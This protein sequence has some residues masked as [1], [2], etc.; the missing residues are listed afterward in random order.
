MK[1]NRRDLL[2]ASAGLAAAAGFGLTG[3]RPPSPRNRAYTPEAGASLRLLRWSPFVK[4]D[5]DAW[6]ANTKKFTERPASRCASTRK[7]GKTSARRPRS[8]PTS[9]PAPTWCCAGSTM[10]TS[11]PTSWWT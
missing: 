2:A 3:S 8:P 9:V 7:A 5:E 4:G 1:I 11:I 6:L 10:P